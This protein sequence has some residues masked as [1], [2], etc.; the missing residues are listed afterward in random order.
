MQALR[1]GY[2][3]LAVLKPGSARHRLVPKGLPDESPTMVLKCQTHPRPKPASKPQGVWAARLPSLSFRAST[4]A[5]RR[6]ARL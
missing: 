1:L 5:Q 6:G 2:R 4:L 3:P